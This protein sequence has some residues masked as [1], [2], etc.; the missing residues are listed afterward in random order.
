MI[1]LLLKEVGEGTEAEELW[2]CVHNQ[3][4]PRQ[5]SP[6]AE[7]R[8]LLL[9]TQQQASFKLLLFSFFLI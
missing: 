3:D 1:F 2:G 8:Y 4:K 5:G 6:A 9:I 7:P